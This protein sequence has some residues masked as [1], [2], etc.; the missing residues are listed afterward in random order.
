MKKE[1]IILD[2]TSD[3]FD[4]WKKAFVADKEYDGLDI[5]EMT[6]EDYWESFSTDNDVWVEE[7]NDWLNKPVEGVIIAFAILNLWN[8]RFVGAKRMGAKLNCIIDA[9]GC[10][11]GKWYA[12]RYDVKGNLY[13]HDGTNYLTYRII[14]EHKVYEI[15]DRAERGHL[16]WEYFRKNSKSILPQIKQIFE[17]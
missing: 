12:E 17:W 15:L 14:P 4:D 8:G 3:R 5:S 1:R 16:T 9:C 13:H 6:D 7:V 10:D 11:Y 2:T